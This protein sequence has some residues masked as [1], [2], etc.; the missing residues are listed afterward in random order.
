MTRGDGAVEERSRYTPYGE[1]ERLQAPG[2]TSL[3]SRGYI[4]ERDDPETGLLYL[5]A[6]TY[7]PAIAL[8]ASPDTWDP[9]IPGV[10]TNRYAYAHN[11]PVNKSDPNGHSTAS[12]VTKDPTR[13]EGLSKASREPLPK[14][15]R[16]H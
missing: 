14:R 10:G 7:D 11:D 4:G 6:R 1:R 9:T 13:T 12:T 3:E 2:A 5:N 8:F 15:Q 16:V